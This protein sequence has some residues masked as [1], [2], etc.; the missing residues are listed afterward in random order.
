[1]TKKHVNDAAFTKEEVEQYLS[2]YSDFAFE[3][4]VLSLLSSSG[5]ECYHSGTYTDPV[6]KKT[7][8]YDIRALK[9]IEVRNVGNFQLLLP[10]ECKNIKPYS[11]LVVHRLPRTVEEACHDLIINKGSRRLP[12]TVPASHSLYQMD[13]MTGKSVDQL[14]R[15]DQRISGSDSDVFDKISQALASA[16]DLVHGAATG[17]ACPVISAVIPILVVPSNTLWVI[18]YDKHG[19]VVEGPVSAKH[20]SYYCDKVLFLGQHVS[21]PYCVSHL[22][23]VTI[24]HLQEFLPFLNLNRH[25]LGELVSQAKCS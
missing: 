21:R 13:T 17:V 15:S 14:R 9:L 11:P 6:T 18:D 1:M 22:E 23:I 5:F 4:K 7:R 12:V 16:A 8:E 25:Y 3:V 20:T 10:V 2:S 24:D 19:N